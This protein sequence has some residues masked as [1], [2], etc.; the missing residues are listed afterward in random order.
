M[1]SSISNLY[2][3]R[4]LISRSSLTQTKIIKINTHLPPIPL[5]PLTGSKSTVLRAVGAEGVWEDW[6][7]V[8]ALLLL[9]HPRPLLPGGWGGHQ[10]VLREAGEGVVLI[11]ILF[12]LLLLFICY[13]YSLFIGCFIHHFLVKS[14]SLVSLFSFVLCLVVVVFYLPVLILHFCV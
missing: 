11:V 3:L 6:V 10:G 1:R 7:W 13:Y 5:R 2:Y 4:L 14:S 8:A 9:L 12:L